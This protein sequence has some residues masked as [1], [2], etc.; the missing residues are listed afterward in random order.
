MET[1]SAPAATGAV[2]DEPLAFENLK[3]SLQQL[4]DLCAE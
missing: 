3:R 4:L 2:D 1:P